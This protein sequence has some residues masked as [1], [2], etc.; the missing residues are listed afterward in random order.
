MASTRTI[1]I[2]FNT[3]LAKHE[4]EEDDDDDDD[5]VDKEEDKDKDDGGVDANHEEEEIARFKHG[6]EGR[7]RGDVEVGDERPGG[8]AEGEGRYGEVVSNISL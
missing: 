1:F 4:E 8:A 2:P 5:D 7:V 6:G 3:S